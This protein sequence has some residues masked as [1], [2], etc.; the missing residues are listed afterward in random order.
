M[1]VEDI[2]KTDEY[3]SLI[4]DYRDTCLWF[5]SNAAKPADRLQIEQVLCAVESNGDL[6][7][8]KRAGRIRQWL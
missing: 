7:A 4:D 6:A 5:A 2:A 8:Y 3:R 1:K